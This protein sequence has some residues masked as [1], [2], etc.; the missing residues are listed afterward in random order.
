MKISKQTIQLILARQGATAKDLADKIEMQPQNFSG[1]LNRGTCRPTTAVRIAN[2]LGVDVT[3][4][5]AK[6][7]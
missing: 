6:E 4:I 5:L 2:G 1:I 3:E 7:A